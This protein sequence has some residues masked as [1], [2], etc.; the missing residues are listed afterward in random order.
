MATNVVIF[1]VD[2]SL[3][4]HADNCK[5]SFLL[6]GEGSTCAVNGSVGSPEKK[7]SINFSRANTKFCLNFHYNADNSYSVV[8]EK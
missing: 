8:N 1:D 3:S 5:N 4:S 7:F 2:N 6:L